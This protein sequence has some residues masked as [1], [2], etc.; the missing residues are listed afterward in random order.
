VLKMLALSVLVLAAVASAVSQSADRHLSFAPAQALYHRSAY[1]HG[2]MHGYEDGFHS[3]DIDIHMGRGERQLKTI[4]E[5]RECNGGYRSEFG[6]RHY[7]K[8][9]FQ[10]GFREGYSDSIREV[11]FRAVGELRKVATGMGAAD[12]PS[13]SERNFDL[14]FSNGYDAGHEAG[15]DRGTAADGYAASLCRSR[16]PQSLAVEE[17]NYCD[18]FTR[19]FSLGLSDGLMTRESRHTETAK[20]FQHR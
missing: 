6:D 19:G 4:K 13:W 3:G 18:A 11:P 2:Y 14:A 8:I 5:Y 15:V 9:G 12:R 1:A 17:R 10:Q 16:M 7:F 20:S